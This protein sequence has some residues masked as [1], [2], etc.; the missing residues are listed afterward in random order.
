M[1]DPVLTALIEVEVELQT[2]VIPSPVPPTTIPEPGAPGYDAWAAQTQAYIDGHG[3][4]TQTLLDVGALL[5]VLYRIEF[6][7]TVG[8]E[9]ITSLIG[10]VGEILLQIAD[11][12]EDV[13][14]VAGGV[15]GLTTFLTS[16]QKLP[17]SPAALAS[18]NAILM[19]ITG[20]LDDI[21]SARNELYIIDQQ[22]QK[23]S[24]T[25]LNPPGQ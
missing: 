22:L 10:E 21:P 1:T 19:Q 17:G 23:I 11:T 18:V 20:L 13:Q 4:A 25:F 2:L 8:Q 12:L 16:V 15:A 24:D 9:T 7:K 14:N 6:I 5:A 3:M